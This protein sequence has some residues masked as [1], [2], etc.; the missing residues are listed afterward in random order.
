MK[1]EVER[2]EGLVYW[3]LTGEGPVLTLNE[4]VF[5]DLDRA[6]RDLNGATGVV[7]TSDRLDHFCAGADVDAFAGVQTAEEG[8]ALARRGQLILDR[9]ENAPVPIVAALPGTCLGG[10]LELALACHARVATPEARLGLPEVRVGILP[11]L[12][13]TQRLPRLLGL[14]RALGLIMTGR[15]VDGTR[16]WKMGLVDALAPGQRVQE[17]A[18]RLVCDLPRRK[19]KRAF[20]DR[21]PGLVKAVARRKIPSGFEAPHRVLSVLGRGYECEAQELGRAIVSPESRQLVKIFKTMTACKRG[22]DDPAP[23]FVGVLGFGIMGAGIASALTRAGIFVR[24]RDVS[25]EA[26]AAGIRR[27]D[28]DRD[29]LTLTTGWEGFGTAEIVI[30]AVPEKMDL[31][32]QALAAAAKAAPQAL[33]MTNTSSLP[34]DE[35]GVVG[36]HFF[37]PVRKMPLVE[38]VVGERTSLSDVQCARSLAVT[39]RKTPIVVKDSPGFLVNRILGRYL[40]A[41]AAMDAS[42]NAIDAAARKFGFPM[43]PFEVLDVVGHGVATAVCE[44]LHNAYGDRF[45][46][47]PRFRKGKRRRARPASMTPMLEALRDEARRCRDESIAETE[48][49]DLACAFGF[50]Y[51]A[52]RG[53]L[54]GGVVVPMRRAG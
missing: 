8:T 21:L 53:P 13:G 3:V 37:N 35:L 32:Q 47:T 25:D 5:D 20:V 19:R 36:M 14:S 51:P 41:A 54:L 22:A 2:R 50:G 49:I 31:K 28:G 27:F 15:T 42:A 44:Q 38:V 1:I 33:L 23:H 40:S 39:L 26:L 18:A 30:E 52:W 16:A 17:A 48:E 10:G 45:S 9:I 7:L 6:V 34:V 43:G 46:K 12:G 24:V 4:E 29:R 11:G